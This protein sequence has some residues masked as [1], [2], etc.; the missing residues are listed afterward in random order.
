MVEWFC[1][2]CRKGE[3]HRSDKMNAVWFSPVFKKGDSPRATRFNVPPF[4][5]LSE[6]G[7]YKLCN[8]CRDA[9]ERLLS[10]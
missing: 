6:G 5:S 8:N 2:I 7:G 4:Q 3:P 1:A 10:G 9:V